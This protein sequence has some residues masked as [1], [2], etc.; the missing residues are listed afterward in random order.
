MQTLGYLTKR[1]NVCIVK[2]PG[3]LNALFTRPET[4][5]RSRLLQTRQRLMVNDHVHITVCLNEMY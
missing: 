5:Q 1:A 2:I 4:T 3:Q